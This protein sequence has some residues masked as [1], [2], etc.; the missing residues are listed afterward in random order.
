M[1]TGRATK[2]AIYTIQTAR[3][4]LIIILLT[5]SWNPTSSDTPKPKKMM[6]KHS[7]KQKNGEKKR[8]D[9]TVKDVPPPPMTIVRKPE[10]G[11]SIIMR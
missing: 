10:T 9:P 7:P 1:P 8:Y 4:P 6:I 5:I 11:T 2:E 3:H